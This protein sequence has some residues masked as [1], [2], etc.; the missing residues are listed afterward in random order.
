MCESVW[1]AV[2]NGKQSHDVCLT[3]WLPWQRPIVIRFV[4]FKTISINLSP[5]FR[6][7]GFIISISCGSGGILDCR[8]PKETRVWS[9]EPPCLQQKIKWSGS[10]WF[11]FLHRWLHA[12]AHVRVLAGMLL[13]GPTS[14][15]SEDPWWPMAEFLRSVTWRP[16]PSRTTSNASTSSE[17]G[18]YIGGAT[19]R[20]STWRELLELP[21]TKS[22]DS[23][24]HFALD[25]WNN[26]FSIYR[27]N[28]WLIACKTMMLRSQDIRSL[29]FEDLL[30]LWHV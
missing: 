9:Q 18:S 30:W 15:A 19:V 17:S 26:R 7:S 16:S 25:N 22:H 27:A 10:H 1:P 23:W 11:A 20:L 5:G 28:K 4:I 3:P 29:I 13:P 8:F 6:K 24:S 12:R 21:A 14:P 2:K